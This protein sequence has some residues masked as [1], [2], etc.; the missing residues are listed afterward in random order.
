MI[1]EPQKKI[2]S[3]LRRVE[4]QIRGLQRMIEEER[5]CEDIITQI[6]AA[7]AALNKAALLI[8]REHL[9]QCLQDT[10]EEERDRRLNSALEL[11]F[12]LKSS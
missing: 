11:L 10:N 12:K 6:T 8:M 1:D 5:N 7:S 3:R 2:I 4:G 9:S